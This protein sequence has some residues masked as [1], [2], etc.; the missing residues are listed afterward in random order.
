MNKSKIKFLLFAILLY[1]VMVMKGSICYGLENGKIKVLILSGKNNHN[2]QYTTPAIKTIL[3]KSDKFIVSVTN[4]PENLRPIELNNYDVILSNWNTWPDVT[5]KRWNKELETAFIKFVSGGKGFVVLHAG[6]STLQDWPEFQQISGGTWELGVTGHGPIHTF[7]VKIKDEKH[8]ITSG[9]QDFYIKDELWHRTKLQPNIDTL[10]SAFS[11]D[12]KKGTGKDEPITILSKFG[13]GRCFYNILGHNIAAMQNNA[14][15]TF[16]LRGTEWAATGNVTIPAQKPWPSKIEIAEQQSDQVW[17]ESDTTIALFKN[18]EVVWQFNSPK[19]GKPYFHPINTIDGHTLTWLSPADHPWHYALWF[20]WKYINDVN[21][22][23]EDRITG[24]PEGITEITNL[25]YKLNEDY[26]AQINLSIS[27]YPLKGETILSE[28]RKINVASPNE[29]GEYFI[30]WES[31]FLASDKEVIF[32]RTPIEGE[33]GGRRWGGYATLGLRINTKTLSDISLINDNGLRNLD[34][35]TEPT[36]WTDISG[37]IKDDST[38]SAG[39]TIF[40]SNKNP[41]YPVPGYVINNTD[42]NGDPEFVY[43]NPGFL[44]NAAYRLQAFESLKL[45]YKIFIHNG[46]GDLKKLNEIHNNYIK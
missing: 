33:K 41:R 8:P 37:R 31:E 15:K 13:S 18:D 27:Y 39:I 44:Y 26:S 42:E 25:S 35:H 21:Y 10:L 45:R 16:L 1:L 29:N 17:V 3:E 36:K 46:Y 4:N 43:T 20:S 38:K 2:W 14:W 30:E 11:S 19:I 6:S 12:S 5:D 7:K 23:E 22:W 32:E 28:K 24:I 9:L 40:D 34:I